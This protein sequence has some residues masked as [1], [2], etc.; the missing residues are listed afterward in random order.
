MYLLFYLK[1]DEEGTI[2]DYKHIA[3]SY[4]WDRLEQTK[5]EIYNSFLNYKE[6]VKQWDI[7][8]KKSISQYKKEL[9]TFLKNN[10]SVIKNFD[11]HHYKSK[12]WIKSDGEVYS[13][14]YID[15]RRDQIIDEMIRANFFINPDHYSWN[16]IDEMFDSELKDP[17]PKWNF[18]ELYPPTPT[19][20]YEVNYMFI[21]EV[22]E[23]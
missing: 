3:I 22:K 4:D 5:Q 1:R 6:K 20:M 8:R 11:T 13:Q 7:N 19:V 16:Y 15:E 21:D 14:G 10:R 9:R 18:T 12:G 17:I 2:E 23:L